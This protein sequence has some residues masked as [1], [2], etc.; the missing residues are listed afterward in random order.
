MRGAR[1]LFGNVIERYDPAELKGPDGMKF[2]ADGRL[3]VCVFGQGDITVLDRS[4]RVAERIKIEGTHPTNLAFG[5]RGE[6]RI[7]VTE[8]ST[9]SVQIYDVASGGQPLHG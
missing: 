2:G 7:Y 6:K 1:E 5:P 4:G 3:Y 8:V 9:S